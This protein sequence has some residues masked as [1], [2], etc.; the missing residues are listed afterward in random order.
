MTNQTQSSPFPATR[1]DLTELKKSATDAAEDI[2]GTAGGHVGK[3]KSQLDK[4]ASDARQEGREELDQIRVR[5]GDLGGVLRAYVADR[6]L[7]SVG[8]ALAIGFLFGLS[9]RSCSR[10]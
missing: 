2:A 8:A 3:V 7:A 6:P 4:L 10:T 9:R 5:V 1:Q